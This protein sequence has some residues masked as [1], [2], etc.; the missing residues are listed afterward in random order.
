MLGTP[1][2]APTSRA[3]TN[4]S[5]A[6]VASRPG[7]PPCL[8]AFIVG[9]VKGGSSS[10]A[11]ALKHNFG[12]SGPVNGLY[13]ANTETMHCLP[14][15]DPVCGLHWSGRFDRPA[16]AWEADMA[17]ACGR[18]SCMAQW[19]HLFPRPTRPNASST[20]LVATL[21]LVDK[22]PHAYVY[23]HVAMALAA[24]L[25]RCRTR[26]MICLREPT[27][28]LGAHFQWFHMGANP[29]YQ[30]EDYVRASLSTH[31]DALTELDAA[32]SSTDSAAPRSRQSAAW[33]QA[34]YGSCTRS[35]L[36]RFLEALSEARR[37]A[38]NA[39]SFR[40]RREDASALS[41][42]QTTTAQ[43]Y[44][45]TCLAAQGLWH[46]L[47]HPA[48]S[49]WLAA[50]TSG[51]Q[52]RDAYK[53][54]LTAYLAEDLFSDPHGFFDML[55]ATHGWPVVDPTPAPYKVISR[56]KQKLKKHLPLR[57]AEPT[58]TEL[59]R[60]FGGW[61]RRLLALLGTYDLLRRPAGA[62]EGGWLAG[63]L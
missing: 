62:S 5:K 37:A 51:A 54:T 9:S 34:V 60:A 31:A 27:A 6:V 58:Q 47:Y 57:L 41:R 53:D 20:T 38:A 56:S 4:R 59:R 1:H 29:L 13:P 42:G 12:L 55:S 32:Y 3:G 46:S 61:N 8:E 43:I 49:S 17:Q 16:A 21:R 22:N 19:R 44:P 28:R 52:G 7:A 45:M 2:K 39:T 14:E 23:S 50:L 36:T 25:S 11:D 10:L 30:F 26:V 48:L 63:Y 24:S 18:P 15:Y 35:R 40:F 33:T